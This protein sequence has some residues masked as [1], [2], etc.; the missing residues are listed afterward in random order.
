[1]RILFTIAILS[2]FLQAQNN[3]PIVLLHGFMG[4]GENEMGEYNYWGG[5]K[6]FIQEIEENGNIVFEL[7]IGPVSSNWDRAVEAYYQLK[8]G[9]VDY[10]RSHSKKYNINQKP[11]DKVYKGVYPQWDEN[12][13][14]HIIGHSMGG[15]TARMLQY[16]L[17]QEFYWDEKTEK[18]EDSFLLGNSQNNW[19]KSITSISTP[20]DGTTLTEIVTKT[21]PFIQYFV[22]VAGVIGTEFYDFDLAHWG[23]KIKKEE[24]WSNYLKRM[25]R[26]EAWDTKNISSW[27]LSLDGARELNGF[28]QASPDVY[29]FSI[30]T[31]TTKKRSSGLNHDP[32]EGT[33]ILIRTRS[34]LLGSRSGYWSDGSKTDSLWFEND[35]VVNTISMY[36][37]STGVNGAD[38]LLEYDNRDLLIPGLWYWKKLSGIDHW[39]IIGHLGNA[40]RV[41][42][43]KD[44]L[45]D[46]IELLRSLPQ[47]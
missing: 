13:P 29:Y 31:S 8:G 20:H 1:M 46:H 43:A 15:Q 22:G 47:N 35:G 39:S 30:V 41:T 38:P 12:N 4:W 32:V 25:K 37:P 34:K 23:F 27:D 9:Q 11:I 24:S 16:L 40:E 44:N 17:S 42:K 19:I 3:Y 18:K 21:I 14:V 33:S 7:S 2:C 5:H 6:D 26:H 10:G 28:L 36:A 45:I